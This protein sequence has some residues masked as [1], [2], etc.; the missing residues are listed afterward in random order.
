MLKRLLITGAAIALAALVLYLTVRLGP[1]APPR[2]GTP[3]AVD[4]DIDLPSPDPT[5]P[6]GVAERNLSELIG[7]VGYGQYT[8][9][10]ESGQVQELF[11]QRLKP[12]PQGVFDV[13]RPGAR[14]VLRPQRI[15][16][17]LALE[18]QFIAPENN[19]RSGDFRERVVMTLF[20]A[21]PTQPVNLDADSPHVKLH[22][23]VRNARF[24]VA[25]GQIETD[26]TSP[27]HLTSPGVD[28]RGT[29]LLV[30]YNER[31]NRLERL[32]VFKGDTLRFKPHV[33]ARA[34]T[35]P[36]RT[37]P[38][39][40]QADPH[41]AQ[42]QPHSEA[43]EPVEPNRPPVQWHRATFTGKVRIE[44]PDTIIE[45][46][47]LEVVFAMGS[48]E[49][50]E[51]VIGQM[52]RLGPNVKPPAT[53]PQG[54]PKKQRS[55]APII[56]TAP[57]AAVVV[58]PTHPLRAI[59]VYLSSLAMAQ[60]AQLMVPQMPLEHTLA[61]PEPTDVVIT[62]T[63]PMIVLPEPD[64]P[65]DLVDTNDL[66]V[67]LIGR[68]V[69]I[70]TAGD[71]RI[72]AARADY[73]A[74]SERLRL[75]GSAD[76]P[77][78]IDSPQMGMLTA[79]RL[80]INQRD[81]TGHI[82][83][84]GT[85]HAREQ[86]GLIDAL[87]D[88]GSAD[89][90]STRFV[91]GLF[92]QW[93]HR[94]DLTFFKP[95]ADELR[96]RAP[97]RVG[98]LRTAT[99]RGDVAVKQSLFELYSD[100]LTVNMTDPDRGKQTLSR[101][102]AKGNVR[103]WGR[104]RDD[105]QELNIHGEQLR[106]ELIRHDDGRT[107]PT[108]LIAKENVVAR[109][110]QWTLHAGLLDVAIGPGTPS[111]QAPRTT[112]TD[113]DDSADNTSLTV[114]NLIAE[115]NVRIDLKDDGVV[116]VA[117]RLTADVNDDRL[118]LFALPGKQA[119]VV[120]DDGMLSGEH[121]IMGR[122]NE[123][124]EVAGPGTLK[125]VVESADQAGEA[126]AAVAPTTQPADPAA[127][128]T[129]DPSNLATVTWSNAMTFSNSSGNARFDGTVTCDVRS[130]SDTSK[131]TSETLELH[132]T[133]APPARTQP[134][135]GTAVTP[136]AKGGG[137]LVG[138]LTG[139]DNALTLL[140]ARGD[141]V[142]LTENWADHAGGKLNTRLRLTG[143]QLVFN[144]VAER[145]QIPGPGSMLVQDERPK[146]RKVKKHGDPTDHAAAFTGKGATAFTWQ[147]SL[148]LDAAHSSMLMRDTVRMIH[149]PQGEQQ[150]V[151]L[152]CRRLEAGLESTGD[153][154]ALLDKRDAH[155]RINKVTADEN[156]R[157]ASGDLSIHGDH[158]RYTGDNE[159]IE[160]WG[161]KG[162]PAELY[163]ADQMLTAR[164]FRWDLV[165][166]RIEAVRPGRATMPIRRQSK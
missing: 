26:P 118:E 89:D 95:D 123:T 64:P 87:E 56:Q 72:K 62:W 15:L 55:T 38:S 22:V 119:H 35:Q 101:I 84:A 113:D 152:D 100:A 161:D 138:R 153:L 12:R 128:F 114:R 102:D 106:I 63:G 47:R 51:Q 10:T 126:D 49:R 78:V 77:L 107:E 158:L 4:P 116:L 122:A 54:G 147:G 142:F 16:Q 131:L 53:H 103:A 110:P 5:N 108:R 120:R 99:F 61:P 160:V 121:I 112:K 76:Y 66:M 65:A 130:G 37:Q 43:A 133:E 139:G 24:D 79:E 86:R 11:W 141:T 14:I 155:P 23:F 34:T 17:V 13:E 125:F 36:A 92:V 145:V 154:G 159:L 148:L 60:T 32:E 50:Q 98:A 18:G 96:E 90:T 88:A 143:D 67:T 140:V 163:D 164:R 129:A 48:E 109:Q 146:P 156:V 136:A 150:V 165:R 149:R 6:A 7:E 94:V 70:S 3:P 29:G 105:D 59:Y 97:N 41:R 75:D 71:E 25:L 39:T 73:L 117:D 30:R 57:A 124:V 74:S 33:T 162:Q 115:Q 81:G 52:S 69:R 83:G 28:F 44:S 19:L 157:I 31:R 46:D 93:T 45:A 91:R 27:V 144:N 127:L 85:L 80:V 8:N 40:D 58:S 82:L 9:I 137:N 1:A 21:P 135:K 20:D 68:P 166:D 111:P 42:T 134:R 151:Q 132:F 2:T 104:N